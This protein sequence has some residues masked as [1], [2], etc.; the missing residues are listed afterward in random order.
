MPVFR[1]DVHRKS[2]EVMLWM[3]TACGLKP[4]IGWTELD[5]IREFA[6]MLLDFYETRKN[7]KDDIEK[8]SYRI[9]R[10]ALDDEAC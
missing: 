7:E 4:V 2:G 5:G 9:L 6:G 1:F 3:E 8:I 10:Q